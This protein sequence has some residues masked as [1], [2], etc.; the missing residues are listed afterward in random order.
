MVGVGTPAARN[1]WTSSI[2]TIHGNP[3]LLVKDVPEG[4]FKIAIPPQQVFEKLDAKERNGPGKQEAMALGELEPP[5]SVAGKHA[6]DLQDQSREFRD[7]VVLMR[8]EGLQTGKILGRHKGLSKEP[9]QLVA[10]FNAILRIP[11]RFGQ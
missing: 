4:R 10:P 1:W 3:G 5:V 8:G 11:T 6:R 9:V 2:P 7:F